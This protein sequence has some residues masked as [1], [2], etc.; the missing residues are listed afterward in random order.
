MSGFHLTTTNKLR[1]NTKKELTY[2]LTKKTEE[3]K[4]TANTKEPKK[5]PTYY[6]YLL[7]IIDVFSKFAWVFPLQI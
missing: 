6:S 2:Q 7:T 1:E 4:H 5:E 3:P